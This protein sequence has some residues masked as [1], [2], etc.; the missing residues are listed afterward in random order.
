MV[1]GFGQDLLVRAS[2]SI[3]ELLEKLASVVDTW[4]H[5]DLLL[6]LL[7]LEVSLVAYSE[8]KSTDW[9]VHPAFC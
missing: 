3:H 6:R 5:E 1:T 2:S 8:R 4:V 9:R 7:V